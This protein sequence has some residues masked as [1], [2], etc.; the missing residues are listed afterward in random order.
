MKLKTLVIFLGKVLTAVL[1]FV[2]GLMLGGMLAGMS[3]LQA[4]VLPAGMDADATMRILLLSSPLLVLALYLVGRELAGDWF[5]RAGVLALLTWIAYT[6]NNVIEAV[7][8]SSYVTSPWF[9]LLT[10]TPAV[11]LCSGVT[12]WLF[13]PHGSIQPFMPRWRQHFQ[14]Q[15][16]GTWLWRLLLA[17]VSFIPI[18]YGFG[19][20]VVPFVGDSYQQGA[21]GLAL[22]PLATLLAVLLVRSV[23]F[24][25]AC[26]PVIIAWQ[27]TRWQLWL[28]LG[29]AL[30]VMVGLLYMLAA[31][32]LPPQM[33]LIHSLEILADSFVHAAVLVWLLAPGSV[34]R[35]RLTSP[36]TDR[37]VG[38]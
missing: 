2:A 8:F 21:F 37:W 38:A 6:L 17:A 16:V 7:I 11:L 18:Y 4:P 10:F 32:W 31:T 36:H 34:V 12:A 24:A 5:V 27:G 19:L 22:P 20:L 14:Q 33:R 30:F 13:P 25:V 35:P 29:F 9:N 28:R 1:T 15:R 23:L 3:G 26:L